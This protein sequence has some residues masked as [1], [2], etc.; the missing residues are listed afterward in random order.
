MFPFA[1]LIL[2]LHLSDIQ[3]C[4][5]VNSFAL[6]FCYYCGSLVRW[7]RVS[8]RGESDCGV[9]LIGDLMEVCDIFGGISGGNLK[10]LKEENIF[11]VQNR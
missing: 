1:L 10:I 3:C 8:G 11:S 7:K 4:V 9:T 2:A 5:I 6:L